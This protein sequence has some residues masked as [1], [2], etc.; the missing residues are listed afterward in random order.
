MKLA[1]LSIAVFC[2]SA[3]AGTRIYRLYWDGEFYRLI[4]DAPAVEYRI[5]STTD[6]KSWSTECGPLPPGAPT[7]MAALNG[8]GERR[9][10]RIVEV[11]P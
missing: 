7:R 1:L 11:N 10:F 4:A 2:A 5:E 3:F 8:K 6:F 9:F